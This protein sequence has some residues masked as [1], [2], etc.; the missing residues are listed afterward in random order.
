MLLLTRGGVTAQQIIALDG[1]RVSVA[2]DGVPLEALLRRFQELINLRVSLQPGVGERP[3]TVRLEP[4][5]IVYALH[6][7][8]QA[9]G[10]DFVLTDGTPREPMRLAVGEWRGSS[11]PRSDAAAVVHSPVEPPAGEPVPDVRAPNEEPERSEPDALPG[12]EAS[13]P[14]GPVIPAGVNPGERLVQLLAPR[15]QP[16]QRLGALIALP[17]PGPNGQPLTVPHDPPPPG[18]ARVPF[19]DAN[20]NPIEFVVPPLK[21]GVFTLPFLGPDG[22]PFTVLTTPTSTAARPS[23]GR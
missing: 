2:A 11:L 18:V 12:A 9:A 23:G 1:G 6:Q 17:F 13:P 3:V 14:P 5:P 7:I 10:V 19:P 21:P 22:R 16:K 4:S 20:G 8:L 15:H